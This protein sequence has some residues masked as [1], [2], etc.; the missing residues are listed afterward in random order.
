MIK[1]IFKSIII[2]SLPFVFS[3]SGDTAKDGTTTSEAIDSTQEGGMP[4]APATHTA[5]A[6]IDPVCEMEKDNT[7]TDFSVYKGDTVWFC[8]TGCKQAFDA[9]PEKYKT[10]G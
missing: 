10:K 1:T 2:L 5:G 3:C 8:G 7:W 9:R 4:G 6:Q